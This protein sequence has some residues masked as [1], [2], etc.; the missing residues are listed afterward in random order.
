VKPARVPPE[1][2]TNANAPSRARHPL[3]LF[4]VG[5]FSLRQNLPLPLGECAKVGAPH[6]GYSIVVRGVIPPP[7]PG[8]RD[9]IVGEVRWRSRE[10]EGSGE[11]VVFVHGVFA[12]SATWRNVL[13]SASAG[14]PAIAVDLPGFGRSDRP[15]PFDYTVGGLARALLDYLDVRGISRAALIGNSLG[16]SVAM[17]LAT[18]HPDRVSALVL[19]APAAPD[20]PIAWPIRVLRA[21]VLGE[22]AM[23]LVNR[24]FVA[25]GLRHRIYAR[26]ERV[27]EQA[28][29]DAWFPLT[30]P[31]TRRAA[32]AAIRS[33]RRPYAG[34][35]ER[36]RVPTLIVWGSEDRLIPP[37]EGERLR[38]RIVGSRLVV[39]TEAGHLPQREVPEAFSRVVA[40]FLG[41]DP[42][43][44]PVG[45]P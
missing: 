32:L 27:T 26:A 37:R 39:L 10:T 16:G 23:A 7:G 24:P 17:L 5:G 42:V 36:I 2:L 3:D 30:V 6:H 9:T 25:Y 14:R 21:P 4:P 40:E 12:S 1:L 45:P 31:G 28:I 29:E 15:W 19:V 8:E 44:A 11:T 35:E 22:I 38:S 41:A 43:R 20:T 33:D 18:E 13:A 34:L